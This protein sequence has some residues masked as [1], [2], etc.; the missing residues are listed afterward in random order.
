M[1]LLAFLCVVV[2]AIACGV[3]LLVAVPVVLISQ[4]YTL[5]ALTGG[6]IAPA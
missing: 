4:A 1:V 3:G 5:R 2:G 6:P